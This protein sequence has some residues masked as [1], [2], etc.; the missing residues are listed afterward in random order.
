MKKIMKRRQC[1]RFM[2]INLIGLSGVD[3]GWVS[4]GLGVDGVGAR[5]GEDGG[6]VRGLYLFRR[7][8]G[9]YQRE[10]QDHFIQT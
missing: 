2:P 7:R 1:R 4:M 3:K 10:E 5:W 6:L 8:I 9:G